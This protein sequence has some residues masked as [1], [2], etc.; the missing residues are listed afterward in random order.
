MAWINAGDVSQFPDQMLKKVEVD[1][2]DVV[3]CRKGDEWFAFEDVC[4]HMDVPLSRGA[5]ENY[6]LICRAHGARFDLRTGKVLCLPATAPIEPISCR[7]ESGQLQLDI[8][9]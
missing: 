4:S 1:G 3:V 8:D 9:R 5:I 6:D 7:I 2:W